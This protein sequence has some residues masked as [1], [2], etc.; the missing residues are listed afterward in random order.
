[1]ENKTDQPYQADSRSKFMELM[2]SRDEL[3]NLRVAYDVA[4]RVLNFDMTTA[5]SNNK[6][7]DGAIQDKYAEFIA[8]SIT[9][10]AAIIADDMNDLMRSLREEDD[11]T[12]SPGTA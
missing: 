1:M 9:K 10:V 3:K 4:G 2:L 7:S 8:K 6:G 12:V 5:W 11:E